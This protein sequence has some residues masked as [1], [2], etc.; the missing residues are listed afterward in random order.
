[1]SPLIAGA[2]AAS[3]LNKFHGDGKPRYDVGP[4][5]AEWPAPTQ[6]VQVHTTHT[7][8]HIIEHGDAGQ[9]TIPDHFKPI[10]TGANR[11]RM[12]QKRV[13]SHRVSAGTGKRQRTAVR[14]RTKYNKSFTAFG[15]RRKKKPSFK[16]YKKKCKYVKNK[17]GKKRKICKKRTYG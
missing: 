17:Y 13:A 3:A 11:A 4:K 12:A 5:R 14:S 15:I 10:T 16:S 7:H 6:P 1:M 8:H 9:T 2:L